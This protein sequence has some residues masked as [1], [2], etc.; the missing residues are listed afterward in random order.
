MVTATIVF[1]DDG[2]EVGKVSFS[3]NIGKLEIDSDEY[4]GAVLKHIFQD[5]KH[6]RFIGHYPGDGGKTDGF[7]KET[8]TGTQSEEHFLAVLEFYMGVSYEAVDIKVTPN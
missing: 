2:G 1:H 3:E 7:I 8:F 5:R 6:T 4:N